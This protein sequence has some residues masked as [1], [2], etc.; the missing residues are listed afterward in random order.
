MENDPKNAEKLI[1][2]QRYKKFFLLLFGITAMKNAGISRDVKK[3][4]KNMEENNA[5]RSIR[6]RIVVTRSLLAFHRVC[7]FSSLFFRR[8]RV[9]MTRGRKLFTLMPVYRT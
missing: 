9:N 8:S 6:I 5:Q 4:R 2:E 1:I 3:E 7:T